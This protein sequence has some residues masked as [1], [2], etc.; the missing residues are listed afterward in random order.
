MYAISTAA[1]I[2]VLA[3]ASTLAQAMPQDI[4]VVV[5]AVPSPSPDFSPPSHEAAPCTDTYTV[6]QAEPCDALVAKLGLSQADILSLNSRLSCDGTIPAGK[7]LCIETKHEP[8]VQKVA[9]NWGKTD[10]A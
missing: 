2:S 7:V 1:F 9:W 6:P 8:S 5:P 4:T 10:P 3:L